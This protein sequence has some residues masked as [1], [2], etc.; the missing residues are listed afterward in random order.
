M[1]EVEAHFLEKGEIP[2]DTYEKMA[3]VGI[4]KEMVD[5]FVQYRVQQPIWCAMR[6]CAPTAGSRR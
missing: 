4:S 6:S 5:E 3:K 1:A 2:A